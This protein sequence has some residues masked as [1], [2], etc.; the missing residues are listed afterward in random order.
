[1]NFT[2]YGDEMPFECY[3]LRTAFW[4]G[5]VS[6]NRINSRQLPLHYYILYSFY[7]NPA[8]ITN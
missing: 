5:E 4:I 1:M 2:F 3:F 7:V 6:A 8:G